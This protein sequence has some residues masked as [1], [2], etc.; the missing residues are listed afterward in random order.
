MVTSEP[1]LYPDQVKEFGEAW[2]P[3]RGLLSPDEQVHW[4]VLMERAENHPYPGHC[5][6]GPGDDSK[7]PIVFTMLGHAAG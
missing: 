5:Q 2:Q 4:D 1:E 3:F 6:L 7:S